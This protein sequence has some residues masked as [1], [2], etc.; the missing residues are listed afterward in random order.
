METLPLP[1]PLAVVAAAAAAVG[2]SGLRED[3]ADG[4]RLRVR[5]LR[6]TA[7]VELMTAAAQVAADSR[8]GR[9]EATAAAGNVG[10]ERSLAA[11]LFWAS[12]PVGPILRFG[13]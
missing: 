7:A 6:G 10:G 11:C 1:L 12:L 2:S 8:R 9:E 5:R 4:G 13:P 3:A